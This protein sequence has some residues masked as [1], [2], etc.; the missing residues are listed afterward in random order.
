MLN[1]SLCNLYS[2]IDKH[3]MLMDFGWM[4]DSSRRG[5]GI[6]LLFNHLRHALPST[7]IDL[8]ARL[9]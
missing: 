5:D 7:N 8:Y 6:N 3:E 2:Y 4:P 9:L 1:I